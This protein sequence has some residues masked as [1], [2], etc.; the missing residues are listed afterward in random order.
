[1][2]SPRSAKTNAQ[3]GDGRPL[4]RLYVAGQLPASREAEAM[5]RSLS[6]AENGNAPILEVV[7]LLVE[8]DRALTD[9]IIVTP[10]LVRLAPKPEL[11]IRGFLSDPARV[12]S[13]LGLQP[14]SPIVHE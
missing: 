10:T 11:R 5:L 12:R 13:A 7:D 1:M 6:S 4:L 9:G 3:E 14:P 8:P 2:K